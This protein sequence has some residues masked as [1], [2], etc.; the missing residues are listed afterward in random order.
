[1]KK[2]GVF[3]FL[4]IILVIFLI[5]VN[6]GVLFEIYRRYNLKIMKSVYRFLKKDRESLLLFFL[7]LYGV[8]HSIGPGHGKTF[9]ISRVKR[10][11][12]K[13][14]ILFSAI[15]AYSQGITSYLIL[16][17]FFITISKLNFLDGVMR[18]IYGIGIIILSLYNIFFSHLKN[19]YSE[20]LLYLIAIVPCTGILAMILA[21][22][23][24]K[25]DYSYVKAIFFISTGVFITLSSFCI[26]I[27]K[28]KL[29]KEREKMEMLDYIINIFLLCIGIMLIK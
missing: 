4:V 5:I 13:K 3:K 19:K 8:V 16:K 27:K 6:R 28:I 23:I 21:I 1:M 14:L 26:I 22:V 17:S 20:K 25:K 24:L 29:L 10:D 9:L 2:K 18:K 15:I 12:L 11:S 7:F